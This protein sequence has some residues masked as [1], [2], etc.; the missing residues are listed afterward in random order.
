MQSTAC[1]AAFL[2]AL[3][4]PAG[5]AAGQAEPPADPREAARMHI[6]PFYFTPELRIEELGVD[7]NVFNSADERR[8]FTFTVAPAVDLRVPFGRRALITAIASTDLVYYH[9]YASERSFDPDVAVRGD[10]FL[11]RLTL[12]AEPSYLNTRQRLNFE[13]DARVRRDERAVSAGARLRISAKS[14]VEVA[15][16]GRRTRFD[17]DATFNGTSLRET[18][19]RESRQVSLTLRHAL[20]PVLHDPAQVEELADLEAQAD[21]LA[22]VGL[23]AGAPLRR[24]RTTTWSTPCWACS[25]YR[26]R[27]GSLRSISS[28]RAVVRRS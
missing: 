1:L 18:L 20:T 12:F 25:T 4:V 5:A 10:L 6:G 27:S 2:M 24:L 19:N 23:L 16:G 17:A 13:L 8:D 28:R 14:D 22:L 7:T 9:R 3:S 26:P 21:R 15:A 11:N